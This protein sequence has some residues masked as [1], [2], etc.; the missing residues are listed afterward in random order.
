MPHLILEYSD[1]I[2]ESPDPSRVLGTLSRT[3]A[4]NDEIDLANI[5]SRLVKSEHYF[6]SDGSR[7]QAFLHLQVALLA[8]RSPQFKA[9]LSKKLY[10]TVVQLFSESTRNLNC[11]VTVE[12]RDMDS[13][14]YTKQSFGNI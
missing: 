3:L 14:A 2:I 8:G 6:V 9:E 10:D 4:D 7:D 5:K 11:S 12:I 1:N 13:R